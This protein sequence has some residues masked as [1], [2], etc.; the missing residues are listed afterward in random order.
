M[1]LIYD[2]AH[3][4]SAYKRLPLVLSVYVGLFDLLLDRSVDDATRRRARRILRKLA[5]DLGLPSRT[6]PLATCRAGP[7]DSKLFG[8]LMRETLSERLDG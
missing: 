7:V 5:A 2:D 4:F 3:E 6:A 8:D 1:P